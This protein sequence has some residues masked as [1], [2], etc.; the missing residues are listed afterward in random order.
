MSVTKPNA[1]LR[2]LRREQGLSL[3]ELAH[4]AG[5]SHMTIQRLEA[6]TLDVTPAIKARIARALRAP[7]ETLWPE[8]DA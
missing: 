3:R 8:G 6:G 4:F 5:C 1:G 2:E 7:V